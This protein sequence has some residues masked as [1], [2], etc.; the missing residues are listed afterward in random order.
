ML[1]RKIGLAGPQPESAAPEPATGEARVERQCTVDQPDHGTDILAE[2]RQHEGCIGED[3]RVVL[4]RLERPPS[5]IDGH[6][7]KSQR[8]RDSAV[9]ISS[10]MPSTKYSCSGSPL[11]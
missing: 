1:D 4:P 5:K 7:A 2:L 10:T 11:I 6:A 8:I 3:A 9:M